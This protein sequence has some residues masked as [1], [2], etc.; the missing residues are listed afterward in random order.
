MLANDGG[1]PMTAELEELLN[2]RDIRRI[3]PKSDMT[4]YRWEREGKFPRCL[5][6]N[7]RSY[8]RKSEVREW[9]R[10]NGVAA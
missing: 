7:S 4:I 2:R 3:I 8:W 1:G 10:A 5:K 6:I 9:Q